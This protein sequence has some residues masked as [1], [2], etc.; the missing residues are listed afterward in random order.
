MEELDRLLEDPNSPP[1]V[2]IRAFV[3][4]ATASGQTADE[5]ARVS[6]LTPRTVF[7][8]RQRYRHGGIFALLTPHRPPL[9]K[10]LPD[11]VVEELV[12]CATAEAP[13][14]GLRWTLER[15]SERFS[16]SISTVH[17]VLRSRG[18]RLHRG[19]WMLADYNIHPDPRQFSSVRA[20]AGYLSTAET[21]CLA[22]VLSDG[23]S[24]E[25][26]TSD[27]HGASELVEEIRTVDMDVLRGFTKHGDEALSLFIDCMAF[28]VPRSCS[29][30]LVLD[31]PVASV[32][33]EALLRA[34]ASGRFEVSRRPLR[35]LWPDFVDL[36]FR[37]VR[38]CGGQLH[39]AQQIGLAL[40]EY[41]R[42][43]RPEPFGRYV[44]PNV[45]SDLL[46]EDA[47]DPVLP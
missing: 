36:W 22:L 35:M 10:E 4:L 23:S 14:F 30:R 13:V 27:V 3:M 28:V 9:Q 43:G 46:R 12:D 11:A 31:C 5:I 45:L 20:I 6:G 21:R 15:L 18:V 40:A 2:A 42:A 16:V 7:G 41:N 26:N 1:E 29:I 33:A 34:Q 25:P 32:N 17:K 39:F 47:G 44:Q 38:E 8:I 37:R 24:H 19:R